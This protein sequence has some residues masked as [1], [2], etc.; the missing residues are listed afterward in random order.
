MRFTKL[1]FRLRPRQLFAITAEEVFP[2]QYHVEPYFLGFDKQSK[3]SQRQANHNK[4]M[5]I[6][7]NNIERM[8]KCQ[9]VVFS[10]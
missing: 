4:E 3:L 2:Y 9:K 7:R 6:F 5:F 8:A 1:L 10:K